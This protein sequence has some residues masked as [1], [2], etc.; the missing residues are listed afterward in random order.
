ML[1]PSLYLGV[2][3]SFV[4]GQNSIV[5]TATYYGLDGLGIKSPWGVRFSPSDQTSHGAQPASY[6]VG[7]GS[8]LGLKWPGHGINHPPLS[9]TMV[10][11]RV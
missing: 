3:L 10:K 7:T 9:S 8:F 4:V 2:D 5:S 6:T 11:E 1:L